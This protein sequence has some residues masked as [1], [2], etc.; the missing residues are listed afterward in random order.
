MAVRL[1]VAVA[2]W[3]A[4]DH[5]LHQD[6]CRPRRV[7]GGRPPL[8]RG[9]GSQGVGGSLKPFGQAVAVTLRCDRES[10]RGHLATGP[11]L[12][13]WRSFSGTPEIRNAAE[14]AAAGIPTTV[15]GA[16]RGDRGSQLRRPM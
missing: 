7:G 9:R 4:E 3:R 14:L 6:G 5:N 16:R 15:A 10:Q 2:L 8:Q 11:A 1:R 13:E 12:V